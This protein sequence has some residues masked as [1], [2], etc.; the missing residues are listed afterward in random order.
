MRN[1]Y[2]EGSCSARGRLLTT[3]GRTIN[4]KRCARVD[5]ISRGNILEGEESGDIEGEE[6]QREGM[7]DGWWLS[8]E[9]I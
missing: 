1:D 3:N 2:N 7:I 8:G 4:A 6:R 9:Q 5:E